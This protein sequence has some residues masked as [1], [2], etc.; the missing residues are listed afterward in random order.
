[1][2]AVKEFQKI[3]GLEKCKK[4]ARIAFY[5][6]S[7]QRV[8]AVEYRRRMSEKINNKYIA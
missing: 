2:M 7:K 4:I 3:S 5:F 6:A 1:M 8:F